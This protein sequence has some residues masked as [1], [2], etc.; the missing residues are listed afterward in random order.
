MSLGAVVLCGGESRRMGSPKAWLSFG[1][2][3]LL[4][5]VVRLVGTVANPV[6]VVAA[7]GQELPD[8][9]G[10]IAVIRDPVAGRGPLPG[11][12]RPVSRHLP[13]SVRLVYATGTDGP[14][15]EPRWIRLLAELI[16][17]DDLAMPAIGEEHHPL[18][19]LYRRAAV[20]PV[21]E[22]M[23][24]EGRLK[25]KRIVGRVR[26]RFVGEKTC[27]RSSAPDAPPISTIPR[28]TA[29]RPAMR[30]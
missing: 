14:F 28:N 4:P 25:M 23:L 17:D 2:E 11:G 22:T 15:L 12:W 21:I 24:G 19:A 26:T 20:L 16:G 8:L 13:D 27:G 1:P 9:P 18:A 5:R 29:G 6:V 30:E 3:R 10:E 7:A